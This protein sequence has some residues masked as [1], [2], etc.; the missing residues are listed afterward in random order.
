M[1]QTHQHT[2][3]THRQR[4]W[5]SEEQAAEHLGSSKGFLSKDRLTRLHNIPFARL[6]RHIRYDI[7]D[8]DAFLE[9]SKTTLAEGACHE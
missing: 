9:A 3:L 1:S 7:A 4:R 5:L 6:G 2:P 8:L